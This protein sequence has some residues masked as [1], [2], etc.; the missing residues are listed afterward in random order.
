L[1]RRP[2]PKLGCG[3]KEVK[4]KGKSDSNLFENYYNGIRLKKN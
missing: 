3:A 2:R 4:K 1:W